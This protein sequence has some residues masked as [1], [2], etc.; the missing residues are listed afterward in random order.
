MKIFK[1]IIVLFLV[2][3]ICFGKDT[4]RKTTAGKKEKTQTAAY[5]SGDGGKGI[6]LAVLE[7]TGK[8][9]PIQEQ[10][11]LSFVQ[12][13]ITGDF[14]KYSAISIID[15]QNLE[16]ILAEQAQSAS[17]IYSDADYVRIGHLTNAQYILTGTIS[18]TAN[19]YILELSITNAETGVRKASYPPKQVTAAA[20]ENLSAIKEASADLLKQM[21]VNLTSAG[22][23]SLRETVDSKRVKAETA[24]AKGISAQQKGTV[25]E[26]L[27]YYYEA[28]NFDSKLLEAASRSSTIS[29]NIQSGSLGENIRNDIQ[30]RNAWLKVL[31]EAAA[32][33]KEHPPFEILYSPTLTWG[34][35]DYNKGTADISFMAGLY[36]TETGFMVLRDLKQGLEKTGRSKDWGFGEWPFKGDAA[37]FIR[38]ILNY[39]IKAALINEAGRTIGN[40][41]ETYA[42]EGLFSLYGGSYYSPFIHNTKNVVFRNVEATK[43]TDNLKINIVSVNGLD[44]KTASDRGYIGISIEN[45]MPPNS[46]NYSSAYQGQYRLELNNGN[47]A[48]IAYRLHDTEKDIIIPAK[49][50]RW[51]V[52]SIGENAYSGLIPSIINIVIPDSVTTIGKGALIVFTYNRGIKSITI[53]A[54]VSIGEYAFEDTGFEQY[55]K[56][57]GKKAG[58]YVFV[59]GKWS[60]K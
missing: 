49:I 8:G 5:Y 36:I 9:L 37:V 2:T 27:N 33:F 53:P 1:A 26:A 23:Q 18:K 30:N 14:N 34:K 24:L 11:I 50:G 48:I 16:K 52:T 44:S 60:M 20:L 45:D 6:R 39:N 42:V 51:P 59:N 56:R 47:I 38:D 40:A 58:T 28:A 31:Q 43:I 57:N 22:L 46:S 19:N 4:D 41:E 21:G 12:G 7:P 25:V 54:N 35:V 55:Y 17:G 3:A 13:S 32:F 15:R 10:W 29:A